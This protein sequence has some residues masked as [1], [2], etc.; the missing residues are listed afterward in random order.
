MIYCILAFNSYLGKI[1]NTGIDSQGG[2]GYR[3]AKLR[4]VSTLMENHAVA[5]EETGDLESARAW[6]DE[7]ARLKRVDEGVPFSEGELPEGLAA[8]FAPFRS[9]LEKYYCP[10]MAEFDLDHIKKKGLSFHA[11]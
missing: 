4:L 8:S 1:P 7:V 2:F 10:A 11:Q 3:G 6:R 5:L 9:H